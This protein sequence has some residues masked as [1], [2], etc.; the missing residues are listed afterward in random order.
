[1]TEIEPISDA[2]LAWIKP[3]PVYP[4]DTIGVVKLSGLAWHSVVARI[5][6][7]AAQLAALQV[8]RARVMPE[9]RRYATVAEIEAL[10][11][12]RYIVRLK[13]PLSRP[14]I[15]THCVN[16]N[17]GGIRVWETPVGKAGKEPLVVADWLVGATIAG[18]IPDAVLE[19]PSLPT[20]ETDNGR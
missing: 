19:A 16:E 1:M 3:T 6:R 2:I 10:P 7:D 17:L 5:R 14:V 8:E 18:P 9:A 4:G 13:P 15:W 20:E 11:L 12:G